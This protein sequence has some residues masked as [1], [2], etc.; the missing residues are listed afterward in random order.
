[1]SLSYPYT[2]FPFNVTPISPPFQLSPVASN[3]SLGW[4]PSCA[5]PECIPTASWSTS[6]INSTL[7]F[8]YWGVGLALDGNV[9]GNMSVR[10]HRDGVEAAWSPSGDTLFSLLGAPTDQFY[11]HNITLQVLDASPDAQLTIIRARVNGSSFSSAYF[12]ADRWMIPSNDDSLKYTGFVPQA[13]VARVESS[14][15]YVSS[16][17][18]DS[19]SMQWNASSFLVYGPCGPTNAL[20]RV[21]IDS[22]QR[23]QQQT[24][25]TSTPFVSNDCLLFQAWGLPIPLRSQ[26]LIENVDGGML[27][28]D[29]FDAFRVQIYSKGASSV[30]RATI[31]ACA[32]LGA[33]GLSAVTIIVYTRRKLRAQQEGGR[34]LAIRGWSK[35]LCLK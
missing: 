35:L 12:S 2:P 1:M 7:S 17:A 22:Q 19:L 32:M 16:M 28:I 9:T 5:T 18:G 14:T 13:S 29:R 31:I 23:I 34:P 8:R 24:V 30:K 11:L 15:T 4:V 20:I 6:A 3:T 25:N 21:T 10:L 26:I 27:S 33:I